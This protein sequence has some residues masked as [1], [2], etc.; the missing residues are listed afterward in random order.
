MAQSRFGYS[1]T[2]TALFMQP[3]KAFSW[4]IVAPAVPLQFCVYTLNLNAIAGGK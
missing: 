3:G 1:G 4:E 2:L